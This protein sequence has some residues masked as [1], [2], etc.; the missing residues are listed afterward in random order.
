MFVLRKSEIRVSMLL[1]MLIFSSFKASGSAFSRLHQGILKS[2][3]KTEISLRHLG[4][5]ILERYLFIGYTQIAG[6]V[7]E[8]FVF[9]CLKVCLNLTI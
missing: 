3:N 9:G 8:T 2:F 6:N 5:S 7:S 1:K 4:Q